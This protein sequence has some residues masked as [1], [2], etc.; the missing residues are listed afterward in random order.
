MT[1][2]KPAG[3]SACWRGAMISAWIRQ[4]RRQSGSVSRAVSQHM[5]HRLTLSLWRWSR[6]WRIF[7]SKKSRRQPSELDPLTVCHRFGGL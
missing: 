4:M 3:R 1:A 7:S 5:Q 6:T 2:N